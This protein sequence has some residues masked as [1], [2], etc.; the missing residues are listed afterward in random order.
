MMIPQ[1]PSS[2]AARSCRAVTAIS[3]SFLLL[4]LPWS[5]SGDWFAEC[6]KECS[7]KWISGKKAALC[8]DLLLDAIPR[9]SS[10]IQHLDLSN[11]TITVI[12]K[13]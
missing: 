8:V 1:T 5:A 10:D 7:C 3:L 13:L 9:M 6:P 2:V 11:N 4:A 12:V